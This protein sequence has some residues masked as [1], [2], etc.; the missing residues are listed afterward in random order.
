MPGIKCQRERR[1]PRESNQQLIV[2]NEDVFY[3]GVIGRLFYKSYKLQNINVYPKTCAIGFIKES[4]LSY[5][6]K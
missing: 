2:Y 4:N 6:W 3:I 5:D 1:L